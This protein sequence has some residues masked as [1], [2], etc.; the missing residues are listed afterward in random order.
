VQGI[1]Y[2]CNKELTE[3]TIKRHMKNCSE[4]KKVIEEKMKDTK[5]VR[6]QFI[7]SLK[8]KYESNVYC[9]YVSIDANL[10][11]QHLDRFIRDIWVECCGHLSAFYIDREIYNDN[12]DEQYEMN[13]YLKDVLDVN[14]KFEYQYDF[15]STT[16]LILEVVDMIKVPKEFSQI[17]I[18]ARN[19]EEKYKCYKCNDEAKY[20]NWNTDE[21]VCETCSE[22]IDEE[23]LEEVDYC[24]SPRDGVCGYVGNKDTEISYLPQNIKKYKIS[25]KKPI[26]NND[27]GFDLLNDDFQYDLDNLSEIMSN[28]VI[29]RIH[30][31][32]IPMDC[33]S[34]EQMM[35]DEFLKHYNKASDKIINSFADM[36]LKGKYSF[37]LEEIIK[38]Y[39]K[40]QINILAENIG[41]KVSANLN[42][43]K[44]IEKYVN[45]YEN[46][47]KNKMNIFDDD[48][49]KILQ[50]YVKNKG[51]MYISDSETETYAD[52]HAFLMNQ[53]IVFPSVKDE[54]PIFIMPEVMQSIV[55]QSDTLD[56]RKLMKKN[57]EIVN[58]FRGMIKAY[59]VL[60]FD[61]IKVL[62]K[63]YTIDIDESILLSILE[64]GLF[65]YA[66]EYYGEIDRNEK[67]VFINE[68]IEDYEEILDEI[69]KN[70]DYIMIDQEELI[71]MSEED[72][73]K[74]SSIGKKFIKGIS[75]LFVADKDDIVEHMNT[76][77]LDIQY[78]NSKEILNDVLM[79]IQENI[80]KEDETIVCNVINKLIKNI[81]LWKYKGATINEK[82][83]NNTKIINKKNVGRNDSCPCGSGK[84]YKNCCGKNGNIIQLF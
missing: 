40:K 24:N 20:F 27:Y 70:S 33:N 28:K 56:F 46:L 76:L 19:N 84:K 57:T 44:I 21:W 32:D 41:L 50:K 36:F 75:S 22:G 37:D 79:G 43:A 39:P 59:G 71:S 5:G 69:D 23:E 48:K 11:L 16:H 78:R 51:I 15:G 34:L 1:C 62:L 18:I 13:V 52:K 17:E 7:I 60:Y 63:R 14:K 42:K 55:K 67:I 82:E 49:Y 29:D 25:R 45:E 72:Y 31:N 64:Q 66:A 4:M 6:N 74:R 9:I 38:S 35:E 47:M 30:K 3:R 53:G 2:Y 58:I 8:D 54:K 12:S 83:G 68:E 65:H 73:L 80:E 77:A 61:D 10:Q 26:C 81:R